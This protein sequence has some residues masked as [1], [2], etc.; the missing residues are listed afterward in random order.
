MG[1][2]FAVR[3]TT[4]LAEHLPAAGSAGDTNAFTPA[5]IN[6]L[7]D[8]LRIPI[9][10][11]YN[12]ALLPIFMLMVPLAIASAIV[13][14][15]VREKPLATVIKREIPADSLAEGQLEFQEITEPARAARP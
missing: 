10:E 4:L 11:S 9:V 14:S 13:L 6:Q 3:L 15:F 1:S 5:A 12:E 8:A 7:P 2:V